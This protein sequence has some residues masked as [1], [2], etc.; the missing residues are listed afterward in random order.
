[1]PRLY[2]TCYSPTVPLIDAPQI[3]ARWSAHWPLGTSPAVSS[4]LDV[5]AGDVLEEELGT[6]PEG[7][8]VI[9]RDRID[10]EAFR[11]WTLD[12]PEGPPGGLPGLLGIGSPKKLIARIQRLGGESAARRT[13]F[14]S[15]LAALE[16]I[17]W[18]GLADMEVVSLAMGHFGPP[19]QPR[20]LP[21]IEGALV[22]NAA[23]VAAG[24]LLES[25]R[26]RSRA[27]ASVASLA[28][29]CAA[30]YDPA[31]RALARVSSDA[32]EELAR[33]ALTRGAKTAGPF[34]LP[35]TAWVSVLS[36]AARPA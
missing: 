36:A 15:I 32:F 11:P 17:A 18:P 28:A 20:V 19:R 7:P 2:Q 23:A 27:V 24:V 4:V 9:G 26:S 21:M 35:V 34:S 12:F 6:R 33:R 30:S 29:A 3:V 14:D 25:G 1:M 8:L 16:P 13:S 31:F 22:S 5:L 10:A